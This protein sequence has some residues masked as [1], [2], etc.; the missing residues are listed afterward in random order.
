[1][2]AA[3]FMNRLHAIAEALLALRSPPELARE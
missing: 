3:R 2:R 1:M